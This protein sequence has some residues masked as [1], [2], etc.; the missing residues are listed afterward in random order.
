M[1][2][3]IGSQASGETGLN[4][5]ISGLIAALIVVLSPHRMP[6]GTAISVA[7]SEPHEHRS[8]DW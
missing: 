7:S 1:M 5:W 6:I 4:N 3:T 2:V 8:A